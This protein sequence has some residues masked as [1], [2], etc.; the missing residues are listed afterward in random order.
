[1]S[2]STA[3][4]AKRVRRSVQN[5]AILSG[6]LARGVLNYQ[7][8]A[9]WI[10]ETSDWEASEGAVISALRRLD[11]PDRGAFA[12]AREVLEESHI[13]TRSKMGSVRLAGDATVRDRLPTLFDIVEANQGEVLRVI[14]SDRGFN[15]ILDEANLALIEETFPQRTIEEVQTGLTELCVVIPPE[16]RQTPGIL[17]L[18]CNRLALQEINIKES[19]DGVYQHVLLVATDDAIEAHR[20]LADLTGAD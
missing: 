17:A 19:V 11:H 20:L 8:A 14:S 9:R 18:V 15:V 12:A 5:D 6:A 16:A 1:M 2:G 7:A 13:N 3:S 4:V 10:V